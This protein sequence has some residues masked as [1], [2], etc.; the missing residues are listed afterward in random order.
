V[1][2]ND[3]GGSTDAA[4]KVTGDWCSADAILPVRWLLLVIYD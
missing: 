2:E 1:M 3:A 4:W